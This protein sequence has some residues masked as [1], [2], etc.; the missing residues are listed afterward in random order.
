[1]ENIKEKL[2]LLALGKYNNDIKNLSVN[3]AYDLF[4]RN[5]GIN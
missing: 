5:N 4:I 3:D 1:M 2:E